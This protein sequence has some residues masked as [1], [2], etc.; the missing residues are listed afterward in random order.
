M[1][2][3]TAILRLHYVPGIKMYSISLHPVRLRNQCEGMRKQC[4]V[5]LNVGSLRFDI[6]QLK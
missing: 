3:Q 1:N 4:A 6:Y 5:V 2:C